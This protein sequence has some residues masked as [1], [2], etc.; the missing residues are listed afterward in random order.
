MKAWIHKHTF[1]R[2]VELFT[3]LDFGLMLGFK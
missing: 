3:Y 2:K 1:I